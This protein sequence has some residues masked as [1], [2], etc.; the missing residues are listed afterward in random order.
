MRTLARHGILS[1]LD[2]HQDLYNERFQGEGAPDW[3]VQDGGLLNPRLGFPVNYLA[4]LALEH[5]LDAFW[6]NAP[7]PGGV[8]LQARF[9]AAWR[10]V[11]AQFRADPAVLG[12]ELFNEPFP[13][14]LW[15][16]CLG[17]G[18]CTGFDGQLTTFYRRVDNAI[19]S[20]DPRTLVWYEPNVLF[21]E[22]FPPGL[23]RSGIPGPASHFTITVR[24]RPR[25]GRR[26]GAAVLTTPLSRMHWPAP[27]RCAARS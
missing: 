10:H 7:G 4:N 8:G 22:A 12:Y 13:G 15:E 21:N 9:A 27:L 17:P 14:T 2:F 20:I 19:R 24:P 5:A 23:P 3:A 16:S 11:A 6:G 25:P 26:W 1:L 18:G